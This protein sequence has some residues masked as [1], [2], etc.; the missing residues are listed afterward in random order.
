MFS[1][2]TIYVATPSA[3]RATADTFVVIVAAFTVPSLAKSVNFTDCGSETGQLVSVDT[4][5]CKPG[6][7]LLCSRS[8]A[9]AARHWAP[10][11]TPNFLNE[12]TRKQWRWCGC[13]E[14]SGKSSRITENE[15]HKNDTRSGGTSLVGDIWDNT[16]FLHRGS[17]LPLLRVV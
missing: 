8:E 12:R 15:D 7:S 2:C 10:T 9:P 11:I 16:P 17:G 6:P 4:T 13:W 5:P 14:R 1:F 3:V